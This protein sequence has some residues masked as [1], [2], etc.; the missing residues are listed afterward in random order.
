[1]LKSPTTDIPT[2]IGEDSQTNFSSINTNLISSTTI[3]IHFCPY[4]FVIIHHIQTI[5]EYHWILN[6][7]ICSFIILI[8]NALSYLKEFEPSEI[9]KIN[10][11]KIVI[12]VSIANMVR[13]VLDFIHSQIIQFALDLDIICDDDHEAIDIASPDPTFAMDPVT[14][15]SYSEHGDIASTPSISPGSTPELEPSLPPMI[16][17]L[18][19]K[20][21]DN[22]CDY[23]LNQLSQLISPSKSALDFNFNGVQQLQYLPHPGNDTEDEIEKEINDDHAFS[24]KSNGEIMTNIKGKTSSIRME[25]TEFLQLDEKEEMRLFDENYDFEP[26]YL[27]KHQL[28]TRIDKKLCQRSTI[29]EMIM[30]GILYQHPAISGLLIDRKRRIKQENIKNMLEF[31]VI[32]TLREKQEM[33]NSNY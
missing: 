11:F 32:L 6:Y 23:D 29:N 17:N 28:I 27:F 30:R 20:S 8:I 31:S 19:R 13:S 2:L 12:N 5:M 1:M 9:L 10:N 4:Y 24:D 26:M 7:I 22:L 3:W 15:C 18:S 14:T 21:V 33:A 25:E 16:E